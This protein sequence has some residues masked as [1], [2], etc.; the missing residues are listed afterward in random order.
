MKKVL[1]LGAGGFIGGYLDQTFLNSLIQLNE[2]VFYYLLIFL[3]LSLFLISINFDLKNFFLSINKL[4][5]LFSKS[6]EKNYSQRSSRVTWCSIRKSSFYSRRSRALKWND[7]KY[8]FSESGN[9]S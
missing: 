3:I 4:L 7:A 2:I 9:L 1:V 6:K 5:N 8:N